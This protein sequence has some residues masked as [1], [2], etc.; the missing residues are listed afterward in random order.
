MKVAMGRNKISAQK[1]PPMVL[2]D[3]AYGLTPARNG[4]NGFGC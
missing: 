4:R 2:G 1:A 3:R